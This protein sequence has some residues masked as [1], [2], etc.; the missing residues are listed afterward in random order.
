MTKQ[1]FGVAVYYPHV[2]YLYHY[3]SRTT[4]MR[5]DI[6]YYVQEMY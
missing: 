5:D 1:L 4:T 6:L 2:K 3:S